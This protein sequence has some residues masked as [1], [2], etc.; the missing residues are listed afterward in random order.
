MDA[1]KELELFVSQETLGKKFTFSR[2]YD[3]TT[4]IMKVSLRNNITK[5]SITAYAVVNGKDFKSVEDRL[6]HAVDLDGSYLASLITQLPQDI[7]NH[8]YKLFTDKGVRRIN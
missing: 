8:D 6:L 2:R 3:P 7:T 5:R 4:D 1:L